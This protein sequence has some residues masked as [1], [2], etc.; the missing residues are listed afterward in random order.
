M[1]ENGATLGVVPATIENILD[2]TP[3]M[4]SGESGLTRRVLLQD[5]IPTFAEDREDIIKLTK[6]KLQ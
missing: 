5:I 1:E 3:H 2:I 6:K 4:E